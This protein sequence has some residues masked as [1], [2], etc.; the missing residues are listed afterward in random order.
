VPICEHQLVQ[1]KLF[2][3]FVKVET[4]RALTRAVTSYNSRLS[5]PGTQY[6]IAA[7]VYCTT[8]AFEVASEALQ[9][10]GGYGLTKEMLIE[11]LFRDA[12]ASMIEDGSNDI[13]SLTAARKILNEY[14]P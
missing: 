11:M 7:K 1:K 6:S 8:A 9:I 3:M 14:A 2:D 4:C 12:R 10:H 5:P 13:L